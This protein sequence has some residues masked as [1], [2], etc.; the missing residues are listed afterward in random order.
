VDPRCLFPTLETRLVRGLFLA[1][2]INGT[3]GYE[4]AG[5]QGIVAGINAGLAAAGRP[6]LVL[7]RTDALTGVLIDDLTSLGTREP[8]RMFTSRAE[9]R[10]S[11]RAENADLRLTRLGWAAGAVSAGRLALLR[12]RE[13]LV[14]AGLRALE[15]FR[16]LP[17][18]WR[19]K[20]CVRAARDVIVWVNTRHSTLLR[21]AATRSRT[22]PRCALRRTCWAAPASRCRRCA[23]ACVCAC[24][25]PA[26]SPYA[27]AAAA[28]SSCAP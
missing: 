1:G 11:L 25:S 20:G 23:R 2:Q 13:A 18:D 27:C 15:G 3:T 22:T 19:A 7:R 5:A 10:L 17:A 6:P 14:A 9:Y 28:C 24:V 12:E 4:E 8:Y 16:L 21:R 26:P